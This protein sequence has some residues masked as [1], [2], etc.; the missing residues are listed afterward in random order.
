MKSAALPRL[1]VLCPGVPHASQGASTVVFYHYTAALRQAGYPMLILLCLTGEEP[2]READLA[3]YRAQLAG[4]GVQIEVC[5]TGP[6]LRRISGGHALNEAAAAPVLAAARKFAPELIC[7]LDLT[8]A[9]VATQLPE[10]PRV[11]WLGDL[12]FQTGWHHAVCRT[13]EGWGA[14]FRLPSAWKRARQ[15]RRDYARVLA[16][17]SRVIVSSH[18]SVKELAA[19]GVPSVYHPYPWPADEN[20]SAAH[21]SPEG[22]PSFLFCGTL[23]ALGSKSALLFLFRQLYPRLVAKWGRGGFRLGI[24]GRGEPPAWT[25]AAAA[26]KPEIEFLGF[27]AD[28]PAEMARRHALVVPIDIPVGNRS[29]IVTAMANGWLVVAHRFVATTN[30]ALVD[31]ETCLLA[32]DADGFVERLRVAIEEPARKSAIIA[33]ARACYERLFSPGPAGAALLAELAA[34]TPKSRNPVDPSLKNP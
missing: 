28:L 25:R 6:L 32:E 9:W 22:P 4:E 12:N 15:W 17:A 13:K 26:N 14:I 16:G 23:N 34:V 3:A 20:V 27:V 29:R 5:Q 30:P 10:V 1:L 7:C 2:C 18:S 31:G 8:C 24:A 33:R 11:V 21:P 19:L